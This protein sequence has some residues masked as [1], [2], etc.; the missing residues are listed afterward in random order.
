MTWHNSNSAKPEAGTK[1]FALLRSNDETRQTIVTAKVIYD[2]SNANQ[3][4]FEITSDIPKELRGRSRVVMW[5]YDK[6]K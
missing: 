1:V 6:Y 4:I 3:V 2:S 5:A